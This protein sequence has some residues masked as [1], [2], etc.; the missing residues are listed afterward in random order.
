M[1]KVLFVVPVGQDMGGIITS[2]EQYVA[3]IRDAGHECTPICAVFTKGDNPYGSIPRGKFA[4]DYRPGPGT[5]WLMHPS[6][7][8]RG[9][10]RASLASPEGRE[11]FVQI[12][13]NYDIVI[14]ASVYGFRNDATE[15]NTDWLQ[16]IKALRASQIFMIHDDH[17]PDRYPWGQALARYATAFVGVQPCS[18]DSLR[19]VSTVRAMVYTPMAPPPSRV[20]PMADR[21]GFLS[22]QIWKTWK[23]ADAL[24]A[25]AP[26]MPK[27]TVAFAGEGIQLRYMRSP[28]K[29]PPRYAGLWQAMLKKQSYLGVLNEAERD[30]FLRERKFLVDLSLRHNSGQLNR[31]VQEAMCQGCVVIAN[32]EFI[33]GTDSN[34]IFKP[35]VHYIPVQSALYDDPK[36]LAKHLM[37]IERST[38]EREYAGY[39]KAARAKLSL[40][41]RAKLGQH[42]VDIGMGIE[43]GWR[44]T[45]PLTLKVSKEAEAEFI[46]VFGDKA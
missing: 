11:R 25:A 10:Y 21:K 37:E 36:M 15:G 6:S 16:A 18:Y 22:C 12:A 26:H 46:K 3:G 31:I 29:C 39:Q 32:P 44:Y 7:G 5:G 23:R 20:P 38:T 1:A 43:G 13:K 2:T 34:P 19:S 28:D 40:F 33:T 27:N 24:V 17:M 14:W 42:L 8:W 45:H 35:G 30:Q 41:D 4:D 9:E